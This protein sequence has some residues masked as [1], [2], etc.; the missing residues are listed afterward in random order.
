MSFL[1]YDFDNAKEAE[2]FYYFTL[3][4][5]GLIKENCDLIPSPNSSRF[6]LA[7]PSVSIRLMIATNSYFEDK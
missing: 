7:S 5:K 3:L 6:T 2:G 1:D 4:T